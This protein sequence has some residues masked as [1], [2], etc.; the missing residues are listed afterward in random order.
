MQFVRGNQPKQ[1][2]V[3]SADDCVPA[4][5]F[6]GVTTSVQL[7][8]QPKTSVSKEQQQMYT[9]TPASESIPS[10]SFSPRYQHLTD[11]NKYEDAENNS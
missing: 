4:S 3:L 7:K 5:Q 10:E 11:I 9:S 1:G 6:S 8:D 2:V